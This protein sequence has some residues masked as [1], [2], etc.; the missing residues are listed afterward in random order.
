MSTCT[1]EGCSKP[2]LRYGMCVMHLQRVKVH[3]TVAPPPS[4]QALRAAEVRKWIEDHKDW[5]DAGECLRWPYS[6]SSTGYAVFSKGPS[7]VSMV[8]CEA[9]N[10]PRPTPK[11]EAAH[12]CGKGHE[13]CVNPNH[14]RWATH[15]ENMHD[16]AT[17]GTA[18]SGEG[19]HNAR[20]TAEQ[21]RAIFADPRPIVTIAV[22]LGVA[23]ST[24]ADIKKGR[25]W[26]RVTRINTSTHATP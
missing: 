1:V 12:N 13:G 10:G 19:H 21:V 2:L 25:T 23:E 4:R 26:R 24:I 8:M 20:L 9:R 6:R 18:P 7:S 15:A 3:G 22:S 14:L 16:N 17:L 5:P 11:H